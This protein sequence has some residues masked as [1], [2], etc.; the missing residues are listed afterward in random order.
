MVSNFHELCAAAERAY[1]E[2]SNPGEEPS[3]CPECDSE[4]WGIMAHPGGFCI[5]CRDCGFIGPTGQS[6]TEALALWNE[7][8]EK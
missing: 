7:L 5:C 6:G 1:R 2:I 8:R 3:R 4:R